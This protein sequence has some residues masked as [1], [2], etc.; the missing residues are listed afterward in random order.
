M[1]DLYQNIQ[2]KVLASSTFTLNS[3]HCALDFG[4]FDAGLNL[5]S[6]FLPMHFNN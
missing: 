5:I 3:I 6:K 1:M 2:F 4:R